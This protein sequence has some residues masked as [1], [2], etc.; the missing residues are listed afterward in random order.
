MPISLPET[1][2]MADKR[3]RGNEWF[4]NMHIPANL[5]FKEQ[6]VFGL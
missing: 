6:L 3:D 5:F 4:A 1:K 2:L